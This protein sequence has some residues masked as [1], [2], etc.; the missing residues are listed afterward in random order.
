MK[1]IKTEFGKLV[2]SDYV[3]A[4]WMFLSSTVISIAGDAVMQAAINGSY[5]LTEI[6]WKEIGS[7]ITVAVIAYIQKQLATNSEGKVLKK[8]PIQSPENPD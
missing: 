3:K 6:H 7:A 4:F 8:E 1:E 2:K 5:S